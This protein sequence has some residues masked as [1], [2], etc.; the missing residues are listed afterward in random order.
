MR[1]MPAATTSEQT[2][3]CGLLLRRAHC[4]VRLR[5]GSLKCRNSGTSSTDPRSFAPLQCSPPCRSSLA[6]RAPAWTWRF[7]HGL[8]AWLFG[9]GHGLWARGP[10]PAV[11]ASR[12]VKN[13]LA[14]LTG[15]PHASRPPPL[16]RN[17]QALRRRTDGRSAHG[18]LRDPSRGVFHRPASRSSRPCSRRWT[19]PAAPRDGWGRDDRSVR[20][21]GGR[22]PD[23]QHPAGS[24][25][26]AG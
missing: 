4:S 5:A 2:Q 9:H 16:L 1:S 10:S 21:R 12:A 17:T 22:R 15:G 8:R 3:H 23:H 13:S 25:R 18:A 24:R 19:V 14:R 6:L 20:T 7:G 26:G 11:T